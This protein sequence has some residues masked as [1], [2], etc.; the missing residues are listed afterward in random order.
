M[1]KEKL[2]ALLAEVEND[3][4]MV[5]AKLAIF[6][7]VQGDEDIPSVADDVKQRLSTILDIE[8][9]DLKEYVGNL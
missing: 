6:Q 1:S 9:Q 3:L 2:L 8:I 4:N 7:L 5:D